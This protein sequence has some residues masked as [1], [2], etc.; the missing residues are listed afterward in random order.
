MIVAVGPNFFFEKKV[1]KN[2]KMRFLMKGIYLKT[3]VLITFFEKECAGTIEGR[4]LLKGG[5]KYREYGTLYMLKTINISSNT[6]HVSLA[7]IPK[8]SAFTFESLVYGR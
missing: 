4:L 6:K 5:Y 3:A 7:P 1:S 8:C 2:H